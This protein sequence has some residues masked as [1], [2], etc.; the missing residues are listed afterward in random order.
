MAN[1]GRFHHKNDKVTWNMKTWSKA[2]LDFDWNLR[3][4]VLCKEKKGEGKKW[5]QPFLLHIVQRSCLS[6]AMPWLWKHHPEQQNIARQCAA[7]SP[8]E[9]G[10]SAFSTWLL[11]LRTSQDSRGTQQLWKINIIFSSL[12]DE[13]FSSSSF[14]ELRIFPPNHLR[15]F[16]IT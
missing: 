5:C 13:S 2:F 12:A 7:A 3:S 4:F 1:T 6:A 14:A 10:G 15:D 9:R 16:K 8:P 11:F